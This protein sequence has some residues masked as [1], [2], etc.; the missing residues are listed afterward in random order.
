MKL[1]QTMPATA[2]VALALGLSGA[3]LAQDRVMPAPSTQSPEAAKGQAQ[4]SEKMSGETTGSIKDG[5]APK[6]GMS[7][8][9]KDKLANQTKQAGADVAK[10]GVDSE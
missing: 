9:C 8:D 3:A 10:C 1:I 7:A 2:A 6:A 4:S 5:T